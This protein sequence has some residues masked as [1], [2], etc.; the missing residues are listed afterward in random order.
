MAALFH[1]TKC[2]KLH[3]L[4]AIPGAIH[5]WAHDHSAAGMIFAIYF[6]ERSDR[7]DRKHWQC[8]QH[9]TDTGQDYMIRKECKSS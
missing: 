4:F 1:G 3:I 7:H 9:G 6:F 5:T 2:S 8:S